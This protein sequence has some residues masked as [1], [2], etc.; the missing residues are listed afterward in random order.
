MTVFRFRVSLMGFNGVYRILEAG[1]DCTLEDFHDAIYRAFDRD[2]PH[3]YSFYITGED[4]RNLRKIRNAPE[5]T[6]PDYCD[7]GFGLGTSRA[8]AAQVTFR[9]LDLEKGD[10]FHYLFDFGDE[11]WHRIRVD[12]IA[13]DKQGKSRT[14]TVKSIGESPPQYETFEE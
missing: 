5:I 12:A 11:W 4:T 1:E 2:D 14:K 7:D 13:A 9:D 3:L 10:V 8:S 6:H